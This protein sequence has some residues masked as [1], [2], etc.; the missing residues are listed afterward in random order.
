MATQRPTCVGQCMAN[1]SLANA[2]PTRLPICRKDHCPMANQPA[3]RTAGP[4]QLGFLL[5]QLGIYIDE[6]TDAVGQCGEEF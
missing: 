5:N 6:G 1:R 4:H 2:A 3:R